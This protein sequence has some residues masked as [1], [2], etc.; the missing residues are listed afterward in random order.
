MSYTVTES[1][2]D[3]IT[4]DDFS[5]ICSECGL[6]VETNEVDFGKIDVVAYVSSPVLRDG[7]TSFSWWNNYVLSGE[8]EYYGFYDALWRET[9]TGK[10]TLNGTD[11]GDCLTSIESKE[12]LREVC[13]NVMH[14]LK[15][16]ETDVDYRPKTID[17]NMDRYVRTEE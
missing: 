11:L 14:A 8:A 13:L 4:Q 10:Y 17:L 6:E 2:N 9:S 12:Q 7:K 1:A 15:R 5:S 16:L 3:V